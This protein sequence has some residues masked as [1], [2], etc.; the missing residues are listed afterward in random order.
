MIMN[1]RTL[2]YSLKHVLCFYFKCLF[3]RNANSLRKLK[4][5]KREI[6]FQRAE[7]KLRKNLDIV[8]LLRTIQAADQI[9]EVVFDNNAR[10]LLQ[11][12]RHSVVTAT[13]SDESE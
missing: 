6:Y 3:C 4:D 2:E 8:Q 12:Q 1:R 9:Q 7:H 10:R 5:G 13:S 11:L